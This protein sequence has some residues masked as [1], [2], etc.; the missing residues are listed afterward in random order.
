MGDVGDAGLGGGGDTNMGDVGDTGA[1]GQTDDEADVVAADAAVRRSSS[2]IRFRKCNSVRAKPAE[3]DKVLIRPLGETSWDDVTWEGNKGA[4]T[5]INGVLGALYRYHYP[6][7]VEVGGVPQAATR[8]A[9]WALK[10]K[11]LEDGSEGRTLQSVVW[12]DF[13]SR[14]KTDVDED[15]REAMRALK[16]HFSRAAEK[17]IN[18]SLYNAR[19]TAV[20]HHFKAVKG[21]SMNKKK[22]A[23]KIYLSEEEYL[24]TE[25]DWLVKDIEAWRWLAK[26]W[27]SPDWIEVSKGKRSNRGSDPGHKY[28]ANGHFGLQRRMEAE[29]GTSQSFMSVYLRGHRGPDQNNADVLCSQAAKEKLEAYGQ[30]MVKRHGEDVDWMQEPLDVKALYHSGQG[31]RHGR[32]AFGTGVVDYNRSQPCVGSSSSST[33]TSRWARVDEAQEEAREA[34]E[35]ARQAREEAR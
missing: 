17:V 34:R 30:Q 22:G 1:G 29:S 14:Y 33:A 19:I 12:E 5:N 20:C 32:Y 15:D 4:R 2:S 13:W 8:W 26:L 9:H 6:G 31:R 35:E 27:S 11:L 28:G 10:R 24:Q 23:N 3:G 25:I 16:K 18:D 7:M 21:Q